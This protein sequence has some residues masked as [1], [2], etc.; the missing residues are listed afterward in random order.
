MLC[1]PSEVHFLSKGC[2]W[3]EEVHVLSYLSPVRG[4][5]AE[6]EQGE[7]QKWADTSNLVFKDSGITPGGC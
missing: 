1:L 5:E 7:A 3:Q 4:G 2:T 6:R